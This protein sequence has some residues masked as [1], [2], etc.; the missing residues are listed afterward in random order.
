MYDCFITLIL[1]QLSECSQSFF[2]NFSYLGVY[3]V[4]PQIMQ[5][6]RLAWVSLYLYL[7][8]TKAMEKTNSQTHVLP[9]RYSTLC[10]LSQFGLSVNGSV[11]QNMEN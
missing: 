1:S 8:L 4:V 11:S 7:V 9:N 2:I 3:V 5:D 6:D 10:Y